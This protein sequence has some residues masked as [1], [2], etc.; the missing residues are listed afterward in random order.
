MRKVKNLLVVMCLLAITTAWAAPINENQARGIAAS[1][2]AS[3]SMHSPSLRMA[4]KAPMAKS[5]GTDNAAYYVFTGN[6]GG[7][8]IVAGDD[9]APAVLGYSDNGTFDS[10][11]MPEAMQYMLE[12]YAAQIEALATYAKPAHPLTSAPAIRPLV[13]AAWSQNNPYNILLPFISATKHA[14]AGCVATAMAQV[15]Y[16]W[17]WP[18]STTQPIP[19]Y[20]TETLKID[21]PELPVTTFEWDL[22][23]STYQTTDTLSEAALAAA[24][25]TLYCAQAVEMNFKTSS[26]GATSGRIPL[27]LATYFD[28]DAGAHF[29]SRY[30]YTTQGWADAL[31]AEIAAGRPVIYSGSKASSGHA[32]ICDGYDGNGM[33]HINWGWNGQSNGYFLLNV[34]NPDEQGT[35]SADGPYGYIYSQAALLGL[36]PNNDGTSVFELTAAQMKLDSYTDTR[37]YTSDPFTAYVSG[38]FY[39]YTADLMTVRFGWGLFDGDEMIARLYSSY[40]TDCKP[41]NYYNLQGKELNFGENMTSGTYRILPMYSEYGQDNWR[42]CVGADLN[43]IEVTIDGNQCHFTGYG[44]AGERN[45]A[46]NDIT[47]AGNMHNGR[48]VNIEL[49]MTNNGTSSNELL[50]MFADGTFF[51]TAF[52]GLAPGETGSIPYRYMSDTAGDHVLTWSW[53]DN[54]SD[55]IATRTITLNPMPAASLS[56]TVEILDVTDSDNKIITSDKFSVVLTITNDGQTTYDEDISAKLYKNIYNTSGTSVQGVNKHLTLAPGESETMQFDMTNVIDGWRYFIKTYFYTEGTQTSLKGTSTYTIVFPEEP[57]EPEFTRGDVNDD[58]NVNISDVTILIDYMLN[59]DTP[60]NLAA[61]DVTNDG[62]V[63]IADVT[64]LIDYLLSGTWPTQEMVYTV[65][66]PESIFGSSW[67]TNDENNNMVKGADGVYTWSKTGVTLYGNFEFKVVGNHDY[68][69]Y[70]WPIG[71]NNWVANVPGEGIYDIVITFNPDAPDADRITCTVTK[72]GD[73]EPVEHVYTVAGTMNLFE[74]DWD[75]NYP[76]NEMVKGDDGIYHLTKAGYFTEGTEI[77]FKVVQDHSWDYAWPAQDW[78]IYIIETGTWNFDIM[79]NPANND[80]DKIAVD[81]TQVF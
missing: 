41:G 79:F 6:Q 42:P 50:Y 33:F 58:G 61:A 65:V 26:S 73:V 17:Q 49:N 1:F 64:T 60:L 43:Y 40:G 22:M 7:Y 45:Y 72:T 16:Y 29:V 68:S 5:A 4:H 55:P 51:G 75:V 30:N 18:A 11:N 25:L 76:G 39:N 3:H 67:N 44:T 36:Q 2:M 14:Y 81:I 28:Y 47:M 59:N 27:R 10:Q 53:N 74:S 21:M 35:G 78:Y 54:G 32:F 31:Y 52:V 19:A 13:N 70:E 56:A 71:M 63:N 8:V 80:E 23:Q 38:R 12:G 37:A 69:I 77:K 46:V 24:K 34:L 62:N 48:P 66:G 20:Q 15:L 57:V 9:R